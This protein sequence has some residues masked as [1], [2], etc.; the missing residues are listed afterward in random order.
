MKTDL[1]L[2]N[3]NGEPSSLAREYPQKLAFRLELVQ[4]NRP[5]EKGWKKLREE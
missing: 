3:C 1:A 4:H 2:V 5:L